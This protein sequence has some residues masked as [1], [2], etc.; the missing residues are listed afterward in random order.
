MKQL[1]ILTFLCIGLIFC[2][3]SD[4]DKNGMSEERQN[5]EKEGQ[6]CLL[7]GRKAL[8]RKD[9]TA[10]REIVEKMRDQYPLALNAREEGILLMDS[11]NLFE[12][13]EQLKMIDQ[14]L[15]ESDPSKKDSLQIEFDDLFQK[16][17]FYTRKLDHDKK[18]KQTH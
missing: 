6:L 4:K 14:A 7:N 13:E 5:M 2:Q 8:E 15:R 18:N 10:A 3:S 11:I 17:K 9:Y 16:T 12:A 1:S